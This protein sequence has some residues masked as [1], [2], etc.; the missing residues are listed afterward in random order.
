MK[1]TA[2]FSDT[3]GVFVGNDVGVLG[4][5]VGTITAIQPVGSQVKVTMEVDADQPIPAGAAAVV[6]PRSVAT[7]RYIELTPVYRSG[8]KMQSGAVIPVDRTRTPVEFDEVLGSL[9]NLATGLAGHGNTANAVRRLLASQSKALRGKGTLIN[10]SIKSLGAATNGISA[11]RKNATST[12]VALDGLTRKLAVNQQ[13]VRT[14]IRQVSEASSL[15]AQERGNFKASL[16]NV[17]KMI[18]VVA[19]FAHRNRADI[20]SAVDRTNHVMRNV[21]SRRQQVAQIL[22]VMPLATENLH[23]MMGPDGRL[24]VR[25][26]ITSL[27]PVV[28]PILGKVCQL[29]PADACTAIGLDPAG[30]IDVITGLLGGKP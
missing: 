3:A 14:F 2:Y 15:L 30:L 22:R 10:H 21:L 8:P 16:R 19:R 17:T 1:V 28:G 12:L 18:R 24:R 4:V 27:L 29:L 20:T 25:L 7:D 5:T 6:V 9:N 26:D 11:Q 23:N 13:V